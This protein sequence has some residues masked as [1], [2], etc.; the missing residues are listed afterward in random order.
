MLMLIM[1]FLELTK[2]IKPIKQKVIKLAAALVQLYKLY[3]FQLISFASE[4]PPTIPLF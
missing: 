4:L 2:I 3:N 1:K